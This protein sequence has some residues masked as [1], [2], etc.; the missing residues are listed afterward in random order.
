[1]SD[2]GCDLVCFSGASINA[3]TQGL[4]VDFAHRRIHRIKVTAVATTGTIFF[5]EVRLRVQAYDPEVGV[6]GST[7][8]FRDTPHAW[9]ALGWNQLVGGAEFNFKMIEF[10]LNFGDAYWELNSAVQGGT[11]Y[12]LPPLIQYGAT[13]RIARQYRLNVLKLAGSDA[14]LS[15]WILRASVWCAE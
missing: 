6:V 4:D 12:G 2:R 3:A 7:V 10:D 14:D 13:D 15:G 9:N 11:T 1:M 5:A 8:S